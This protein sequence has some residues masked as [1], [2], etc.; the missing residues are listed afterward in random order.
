MESHRARRNDRALSNTTNT[1]RSIIQPN[2]MAD[3][4]QCCQEKSQYGKQQR[5]RIICDTINSAMKCYHIIG[6]TGIVASIGIGRRK[7]ARYD[8]LGLCGRDEWW[9][10]HC[11]TS[12]NRFHTIHNCLS[13]WNIPLTMYLTERESTTDLVNICLVV[14]CPQ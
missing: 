11:G 5:G 6:W 8:N 2:G 4:I 1:K 13:C 10:I 9:I 14:P 12:G 3:G 7:L